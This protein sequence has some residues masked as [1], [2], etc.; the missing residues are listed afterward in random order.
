[1]VVVRSGILRLYHFRPKPILFSSQWLL[2]HQIPVQRFSVI[3]KTYLQG[4]TQPSP[5]PNPLPVD[6]ELP[7]D[8]TSIPKGAWK[9]TAFKMAESALTTLASI[10]IL[11]LIGYSYTLYYK[12][13]V[14]AKMENAFTPGDPV[15]DLA[16]SRGASP[17]G[18]SASDHQHWVQRPEQSVIDAIIA[19]RLQEHY[20]LLI[21]EKGV[22]KSSMLIDAMRKID[23]EG[24]A[25]FEAHAD[26]EI[27]RVRLG[28]SLDFEYHEDN[29]GSLFSI[30]GPRDASAILDI[31]RAFNKLEKV[32]LKRRKAVGRPLILII[33]SVH[34]LRDDEDGRDLIELIQQRAEQWA[35][36]NLVTVVMN[37]DDY[38][39]Y[40]RLKNYAT[41]LK[42]LPVLD[43]TKDAA[44]SALKS[45]RL[46][47]FNENTSKSMLE[48]VYS[49]VG[50]RVSFLSRVA[51]EKNMLQVCQ[52]IEEAEKT[53][54]LN[55]CWILGSEM[56]DDVMDQQKFASAAMVLAKAL[57][58]QEAEQHLDH[59]SDDE[60]DTDSTGVITKSVK[61]SKGNYVLPSLP[62]HKAREVMTRADFI[63]AYDHDNIFTISAD[64]RVRADS[65]PMM[66]AFRSVCN[67]PGFAKFLE[68]TLDRI[69]DIES[70]G[71][72]REL[73]IKDLW[74]G[75]KYKLMV[76][77]G[78]GYPSHSIEMETLPG[79]DDDEDEDD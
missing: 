52:Y 67:E 5:D 76:A 78:K 45:Y 65:V 16:Y 61:D 11:G 9:G 7:P 17:D 43:L 53:W 77:T 32:A 31:E 64:G 57:V 6:N 63:Q 69:S 18:E 2:Q 66:T 59:Q 79:K 22:G 19:G 70:L 23:G 4:P 40:E 55:K 41:R 8:S 20:Y 54:F 47:Y 35:A 46:R 56:D 72:T 74:K 14:L 49:R 27:F 30:R 60:Q 75:G 21:G 58:E 51:K 1:M 62:L 36:S 42:V 68:D 71:R 25:M 34:L 12:R 10:T 13:M 28:K 38:W 73:T 37:S 26:L 29:I 33:N 50:G 48:E 15:L 44:L 39:V 3:S 24:V